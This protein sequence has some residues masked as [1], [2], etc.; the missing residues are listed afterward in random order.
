MK[1]KNYYDSAADTVK[2]GLFR[3]LMFVGVVWGVFLLDE[4][5]GL[6]TNIE[7]SQ[8]FDLQPRQLSGVIGIAT[9]P[10][11]HKNLVHIISN[12]IPLI[13]LLTLLAI[14]RP[15]IWRIVGLIIVLGGSMT[16]LIGNSQGAHEGSS[17]L[18]FGLITFLISSSLFEIFS[19]QRG[20]ADRTSLRVSM[21]P[22]SLKTLAISILVGLFFGTSLLRGLIPTLSS[23]HQSISWSG[24]WCGAI[25]GV[26]VAYWS[27]RSW[28]SQPKGARDEMATPEIPT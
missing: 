11:I 8:W 7:L 14:T 16:W 20:M 10:F 18:V 25:A 28:A 5:V 1:L 26:L 27:A 17:G 4:I 9:M 21:K 15:Q 24:H 12:T 2:D 3:V 19:V 6:V 22:K 13:V 23:S